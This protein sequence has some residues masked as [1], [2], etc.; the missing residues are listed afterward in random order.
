MERFEIYVKA[1]GFL[2]GA[3]GLLVLCGESA[4][5]GSL[6]VRFGVC[7]SVSSGVVGTMI[8]CEL[9]CFFFFFCSFF[10]GGRDP[11]GS[12]LLLRGWDLCLG[13]AVVRVRLGGGAK[14]AVLLC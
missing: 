12:F 14:C 4:F 2:G 10:W 9:Y 6:M 8:L 5:G 3:G 11:V 1:I 7:S 13:C